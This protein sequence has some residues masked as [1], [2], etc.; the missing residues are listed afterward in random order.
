MEIS[1][2][3]NINNEINLIYYRLEDEKY[4]QYVQYA[5]RIFG[6]TFVENNKHNITL[7]INGKENEL[8][9]DY[10][11]KKGIN[12]IQM[13]I[14]DKLTNLAHMFSYCLSLADIGELKYLNT[15]EVNDFSA[16]FFTCLMLSDISSLQNWNVSNGKSFGQMF[17]N[18][19]ALKSLNGLQNWNVSNATFFRDMFFA[20][21]SLSDIKALENWNVS[22]AT[23]F[24]G[25]FN[26]A[27]H[28][29]A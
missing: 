23:F 1:N 21:T 4:A 10:D 17:A 29:Q 25:M 8:V 3:N 14:K 5:N 26:N 7:K 28:Y 12:I 24:L 2:S 6:S 27:G 18:C 9:A 13:I 11:L 22:N 19:R 15:E 16:M 20:C